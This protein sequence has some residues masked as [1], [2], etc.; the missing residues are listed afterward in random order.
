MFAKARPFVQPET[1]RTHA[2]LLLLLFDLLG[3]IP[4]GRPDTLTLQDPSNY[5]SCIGSPN[6][7]TFCDRESK[8]LF[9][10]LVKS[11]ISRAQDGLRKMHV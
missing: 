4:T 6:L 8:R 7:H 5:N 2:A 3:E 1:A 10:L 9:D 11:S